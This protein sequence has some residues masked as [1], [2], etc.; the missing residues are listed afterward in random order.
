MPHM[1]IYNNTGVGYFYVIKRCFVKS[2]CFLHRDYNKKL[3]KNILDKSAATYTLTI[4]SLTFI[5]SGADIKAVPVDSQ[6]HVKED[7]STLTRIEALNNNGEHFVDKTHLTDIAESSSDFERVPI[8]KK[9]EAIK[10]EHRP[11]RE[12]T[13]VIESGSSLMQIEETNNVILGGKFSEQEKRMEHQACDY[14]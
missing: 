13:G 10:H 5:I 14:I 6:R 11:K 8:Q 2:S 1:Y 12:K 7:I 4:A 9:E 3:K